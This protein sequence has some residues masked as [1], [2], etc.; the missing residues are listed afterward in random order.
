MSSD[1]IKFGDILM[2]GD[3]ETQQKREK[4][5]R[6][7]FWPTFRRAVRHVPFGR[8]AVAAFYCAIDP[9]T[10]VRV[11]GILLAAFGYFVMPVDVVPDFLAV[12]GFTDDMA[13]L[14]TALAMISGHIADRHYEAAD[15][16]L[17]DKSA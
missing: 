9:K 10:P 14:T 8:D 17:A 6:A 15:R 1:D 12:V 16:A 13:V 11:R 4:S 7:K 3:E 5:V 2:P